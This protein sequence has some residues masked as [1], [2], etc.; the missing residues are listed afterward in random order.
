MDHFLPRM[1]KI[2]ADEKTG[3]HGL[4]RCANA[5]SVL[6]K[7]LA[8]GL[9]DAFSKHLPAWRPSAT[10]CFEAYFKEKYQKPDAGP[11]AEQKS[12]GF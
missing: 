7:T 3:N 9:A 1:G 6:Q 12:N 4:I 2:I 5:G 8:S 11:F 10:R